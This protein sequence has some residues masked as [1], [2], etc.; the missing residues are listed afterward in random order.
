[1]AEDSV[2]LECDGVTACFPTIRK[3]RVP[4]KCQEIHT[5]WHTVTS[6]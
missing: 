2:L 4:L 5:Q 3:H 6:K 1:M